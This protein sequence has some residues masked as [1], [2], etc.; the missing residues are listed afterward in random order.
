MKIIKTRALNCKFKDNRNSLIIIATKV[1][2]KCIMLILED[3]DEN[4]ENE[5][6]VSKILN[7][8]INKYR[9]IRIGKGNNTKKGK[10]KEQKKNKKKKRK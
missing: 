2:K 5:E 10:K 4:K 1:I 9:N 8:K 6:Q 7:I 3:L